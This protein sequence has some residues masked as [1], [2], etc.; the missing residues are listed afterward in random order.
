[1][2]LIRYFIDFFHINGAGV[3]SVKY[4][5]GQTYPSTEETLSHV[6]AG[7]AELLVVDISAADESSAA[8]TTAPINDQ[9]QNDGNL[10]ASET[11]AANADA[12]TVTDTTAQQAL[13]SLEDSAA[14]I[15]PANG[16][17]PLDTSVSPA[18]VAVPAEP[19]P[20]AQQAETEHPIETAS[21]AAEPAQTS[22]S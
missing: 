10:P 11:P 12:P 13:P 6:E 8:D 20:P 7:H 3:Q 19:V 18:Q 21:S 2:N 22:Q 15:E 5:K 9:P 16:S 14:V 17:T 4:A 1:M